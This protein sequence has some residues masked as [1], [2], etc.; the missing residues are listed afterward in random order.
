VNGPDHAL[1]TAGV[2]NGAAGGFDPAGQR[3]FGDEPVTPDLV[4]QLGF[5]YH[6]V[7]MAEQITEY[8]ENL[9]LDFYDRAGAPQFPALEAQLAVAESFGSGRHHLPAY[10]KA[11]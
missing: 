4:Q 2:A 6:P 3:R 11:S 7:P 1:I 9:R 8:V 10:L 5:R